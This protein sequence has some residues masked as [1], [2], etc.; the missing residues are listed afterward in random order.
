[1][2]PSS[3]Y[4]PTPPPNFLSPPPALMESITDPSTLMVSSRFCEFSQMWQQWERCD[5]VYPLRFL[6]VCCG[7]S[8][9]KQGSLWARSLDKLLANTTPHHHSTTSKPGRRSHPPPYFFFSTG[10]SSTCPFCFVYIDDVITSGHCTPDKFILFT[11]ALL[12]LFFVLE[13]IM[14]DI[15][16]ERK[17]IAIMQRQR[18]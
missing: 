4:F 16:L 5:D 2:L 9:E 6:L 1:M 14:I 12:P 17:K 10:Y 11:P 3:S 15:F 13:K 8:A 18:K 7:C